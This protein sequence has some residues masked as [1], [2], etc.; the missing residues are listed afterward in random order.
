MEELS[1]SLP[2]GSLVQL[3]GF[4]L[5]TRDMCS[6][7]VLQGETTENQ[8]RLRQERSEPIRV[9]RILQLCSNCRSRK[10]SLHQDPRSCPICLDLSIRN[11]RQEKQIHADQY[12]HKQRRV[13]V[14]EKLFVESYMIPLQMTYLP[15]SREAQSKLRIPLKMEVTTVVRYSAS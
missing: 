6:S 15:S 2:E 14:V 11:N 3:P 13:S 4:L 12:R 5:A 8:C 10:E 7:W 1:A 9:D